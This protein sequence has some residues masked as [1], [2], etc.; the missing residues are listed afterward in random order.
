MFSLFAARGDVYLRGITLDELAAEP[1]PVPMLKRVDYKFVLEGHR[2]DLHFANSNPSYS[3]YQGPHLVLKQM[4][5]LGHSQPRNQFDFD[6]YETDPLIDMTKHYL[7][8]DDQ[9]MRPRLGTLSGLGN[10]VWLNYVD[11]DVFRS[12]YREIQRVVDPV[13]IIMARSGTTQIYAQIGLR[14]PN[15]RTGQAV[16]WIKALDFEEGRVS[17]FYGNVPKEYFEN[18][19]F[20][21][22]ENCWFFPEKNP[23]KAMLRKWVKY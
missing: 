4:P 8:T 9:I 12:A 7:E 13:G 2:H 19:P 11:L 23:L 3:N 22:K 15:I 17:A 6:K 1:F 20:F 21:N 16:E 14:V 5:C 10:S 18:S